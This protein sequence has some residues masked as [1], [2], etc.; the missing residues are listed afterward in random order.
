[1]VALLKTIWENV[2]I[3]LV[4]TPSIAYCYYSILL[5]QQLNELLKQGKLEL[6]DGGAV[7]VSEVN[8]L[9]QFRIF[10]GSQ[11]QILIYLDGVGL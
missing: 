5:F 4:Y 10:F 3:D 9:L 7:M 2:L 6:D 1:M 8:F 11:I